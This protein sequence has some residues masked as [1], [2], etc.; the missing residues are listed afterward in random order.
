MH[1]KAQPSRRGRISQV[2]QI[3]DI[4]RQ[5]QPPLAFHRIRR[6][7]GNPERAALCQTSLWL[8]PENQN[9]ARPRVSGLLP[10]ADFLARASKRNAR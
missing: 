2:V 9:V 6:S 10:T 4:H 8:P 3:T 7:V 5:D 1:R